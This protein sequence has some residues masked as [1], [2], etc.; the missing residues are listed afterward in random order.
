A[1]SANAAA[2]AGAAHA[3]VAEARRAAAEAAAAADLARRA[4]A[5][6]QRLADRAKA[7]AR[8]ARV[9]A[10]SAGEHCLAAGAAA[11]EA[12]DHAWDAAQFAQ[13]SQAAADA[14]VEAA[15]AAVEAVEEARAV[16]AEAREAE[17]S[18]LAIEKE[19][20]I[21]VARVSALAEAELL[22]RVRREQTR[23]S[24]YSDEV[25]ALIAAAE[26]ALQAD[27]VDEAVRAAREAAVKIT[28]ATS[29]PGAW[30]RAAAELALAGTD[31]DMVRWITEGRAAAQGQDDQMVVAGLGE[32][33]TQRVRSA[34][35][36]VLQTEDPDEARAFLTH[37]VVQAA[38]ED[39]RAAIL[40]ILGASPGTAVRGAAE[41]A[42][43]DG[44]AEAL[45]TFF[46]TDLAEAVTADDTAEAFR[47]L[48]SGGIYAQ[49]A[50]EVALE[51]T[52]ASRRRFVAS[53]RYQAELLDHDRE[54][55]VNAIRASINRAADL[56][57]T[58]MRDAA[59]ACE[60]A[61]IANDA[62]DEAQQWAQRAN[63][64]YEAARAA[65]AEAQRLADLATRS[66]TRAQEL[67]VT[68]KDA[69]ATARAAA[70]A[71]DGSVMR[72]MRS[73]GRASAFAWS[74]RASA[75][76]AH[77]D[78][79]AAGQDA[80]AARRAADEAWVY[81]IGLAFQ[82]F[83][84][85]LAGSPPAEEGEYADPFGIIPKDVT[86]PRDWAWVADNVSSTAGG[87]SAWLAWV[88]KVGFGAPA[89]LI[90]QALGTISTVAGLGEIIAR[91]QYTDY[92]SAAMKQE[93][94]TWAISTAISKLPYPASAVTLLHDD[95]LRGSWNS[96]FETLTGWDFDVDHP[97]PDVTSDADTT[98]VGGWVVRAYD[99]ITGFLRELVG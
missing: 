69:A 98:A 3:E 28:A 57:N 94:G 9:R 45:K 82:Q 50:A 77:A 24:W 52:H 46:T 4:A 12:A 95:P 22:E 11:E 38:A 48:D 47:I 72:A 89:A 78:A 90:G 70:V 43:D 31:D 35:L 54:S 74:A 41:A 58:A 26:E 15:T 67:A 88:P 53:L 65:K 21:T 30:T 25:L 14:A 49:A 68:A 20:A 5:T 36:A 37:G 73:A 92:H 56:A 32:T 8:E 17:T 39:N 51:G 29:T 59:K 99:E 66:A 44:S 80:V 55:H 71:A 93:I 81:T 18:R 7:A 13:R 83:Q 16:E 96:A 61:R 42:L 75:T 19:A 76:R 87:F 1:E 33:S 84:E 10:R 63:E 91:A 79:I 6:T 97:L 85:V 34:A 62:R 2:A 23:E 64:S 40:Q 60:A 86:N 27:A